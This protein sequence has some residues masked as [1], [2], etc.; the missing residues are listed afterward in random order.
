MSRRIVPDV[1]RNQKIVSLSP[2]DFVR[3]AA[4]MMRHRHVGSVLVMEGDRLVG[5]F[6]ER[7]IVYRVVSE[8]R[9]PDLTPLAQVMTKDPDAIEDKATALEAL[10]RMHERGYRHLPVVDGRGRVVGIV[11]QRDFF[12]EEKAILESERPARPAR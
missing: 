1:V 10:R 4:R 7:D 9:D 5:I 2:A 3:D 8:G 11:S 6:T 12:G